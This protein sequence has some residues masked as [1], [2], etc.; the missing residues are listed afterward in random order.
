[1]AI[2]LRI[3]GNFYKND[4]IAGNAGTVFGVLEYAEANPG[5]TLQKCDKFNFEPKTGTAISSFFA[6]YTA[7]VP[8]TVSGVDYGPGPF[9]LPENLATTPIYSV[10]Q[11]YIYDEKGVD[12]T[13]LRTRISATPGLGNIKP[14]NEVEVND[15][16]SVV[17]RLVN[18]LSG[19]NKLPS[20]AKRRMMA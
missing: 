12:V 16:E 2:R 5:A 1:M 10:W 14:I 17:F 4:S 18:I 11:Y 15:G 13:V 9:F 20:K 8:S 3:V 19:E 7:A 6:N